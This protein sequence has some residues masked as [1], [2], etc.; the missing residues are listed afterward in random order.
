MLFFEPELLKLHT[1][2]KKFRNDS[3]VSKTWREVYTCVRSSGRYGLMMILTPRAISVLCGLNK[4][5]DI[6]S[7]YFSV[8]LSKIC[9]DLRGI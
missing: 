5:D 8:E 9:G 7:D 4:L 1:T 2:G 3:T 6:D